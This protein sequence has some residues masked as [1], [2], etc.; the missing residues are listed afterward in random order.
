MLLKSDIGKIKA[1][2]GYKG[3]V[4]K[5]YIKDIDF[6]GNNAIVID[7]ET[8]KQK[9]LSLDKTFEEVDNYY[10]VD[11]SYLISRGTVSYYDYARLERE[12]VYNDTIVDAFLNFTG[13]DIF[14]LN[15]PEIVR[16]LCHLEVSEEMRKRLYALKYRPV[17]EVEDGKIFFGYRR[18]VDIKRIGEVLDSYIKLKPINRNQLF[19]IDKEHSDYKRDLLLYERNNFVL[20]LSEVSDDFLFKCSSELSVVNRTV[21]RY[22]HEFY[23]G[24]NELSCS[25]ELAKQL[26]GF[27]K[28]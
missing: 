7:L 19:F 14:P 5:Y 26:G 21:L 16:M 13:A 9:C 24:V 20:N 6:E 23:I 4:T 11:M 12:K 1:V 17:A 3:K 18:V 8:L 2:S 22:T 28:E 25:L 15:N 10:P 27:I